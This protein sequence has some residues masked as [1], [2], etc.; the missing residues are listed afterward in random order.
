ML[1]RYLETTKTGS[2]RE[3]ERERER[4]RDE[5]K[6]VFRVV[7]SPELTFY[8]T[9]LSQLAWKKTDKK[10]MRKSSKYNLY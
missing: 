3:R 5:W 6:L 9:R 1:N 4:E 10:R 2:S 7:F 8:N